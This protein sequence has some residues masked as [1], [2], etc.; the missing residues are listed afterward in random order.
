MRAFY[1][2]IIAIFSGFHFRAVITFIKFTLA[3]HNFVFI[4]C[5]HTAFFTNVNIT[6]FAKNAVPIYAYNKIES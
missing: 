1:L 5:G 2:I 4:G 3:A 6:V